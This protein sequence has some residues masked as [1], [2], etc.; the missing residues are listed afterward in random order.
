[1]FILYNA[2][3][4]AKPA[5]PHWNDELAEVSRPPTLLVIV[6]VLLIQGPMGKSPS[7]LMRECLA[8]KKFCQ[9]GVGVRCIGST[10]LPSGPP[11][12]ISLFLFS[13]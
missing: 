8:L 7:R 12:D 11:C 6:L 4:Q 1:L 2:I 13:F 9:L 3:G 10:E 5:F